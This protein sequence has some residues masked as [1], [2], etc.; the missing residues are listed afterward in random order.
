MNIAVALAVPLTIFMPTEQAL[1]MLIGLYGSGI[2]GGSISA[3]L[4]N[5]PG[6]PASRRDDLRR[7]S[8]GARR[9]RD[10]GAAGPRLIASV[11]GSVWVSP[12][13]SS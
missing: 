10:E 5:A 1:V 6:T 11:F 13:R 7:L 2:F 8:H 12:S 9:A 4:L 3:I